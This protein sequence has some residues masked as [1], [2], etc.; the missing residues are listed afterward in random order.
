MRP[1][2]EKEEIELF[3]SNLNKDDVVLEW[4]AGGS[5][6]NFSKLVK[7]YISVEHNVEW[8]YK[9]ALEVQMRQLMNVKIC[10]MPNNLP[11]T[12][13]VKREQ[14]KDYVEIVHHLNIPHFDKV[15]IDGRAR[16]WCGIEVLDYIDEDSLVFVH[17]FRDRPRYYG[18]LKYYDVVET[19]E[20]IY[21][22]RKK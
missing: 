9:I 8:H 5:T 3:K 21:M 4:G 16:L 22:L 12:K 13:P 11:K 19:A 18:L 15:L 20:T 1:W 10:Y 7:S 6:L 2:M 17:D 14:F